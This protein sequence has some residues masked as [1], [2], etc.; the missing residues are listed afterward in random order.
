[1]KTAIMRNGKKLKGSQIFVNE[2]MTRIHG[3]L[4]WEAHQLHRDGKV[5]DTWTRDGIIY[6]NK[7]EN[8]IKSFTAVH[9]CRLFMEQL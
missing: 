1:M 3:K 4:A 2:D 9:E 5:L 6:V 7:S 8:N